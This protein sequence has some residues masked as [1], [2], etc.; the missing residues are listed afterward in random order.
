[1]WPALRLD[2]SFLFPA[3]C[4]KVSL[5]HAMVLVAVDLVWAGRN[6]VC[7]RERERAREREREGGGGQKGGA[8][9]RKKRGGGD[10]FWG[11]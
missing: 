4:S 7:E 1:M 10:G 11:P 3:L 8:S 6:S 5:Y 9:Q 2:I